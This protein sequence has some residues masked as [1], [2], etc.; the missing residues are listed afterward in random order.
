MDAAEVLRLTG[1]LGEARS[2][3]QQAMETYRIKG[4]VHEADEAE[5]FLERFPAS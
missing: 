5:V 4:I 1:R 2:F 3:A